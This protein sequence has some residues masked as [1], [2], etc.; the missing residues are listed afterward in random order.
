VGRALRVQIFKSK[1]VLVFMNFPAWHFA[2]N[3]PAE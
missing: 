2:A 3:D 1:N